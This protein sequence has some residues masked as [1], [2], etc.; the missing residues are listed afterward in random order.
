M[1]GDNPGVLSHLAQILNH[2]KLGG[3]GKLVIFPVDQG[4]EH[5]PDASF[6]KNPPAY[7][8]LYH[9]QLAVEAGCSAYAA[10]FGFIDSFSQR[11]CRRD[12]LNFK[13]Q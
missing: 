4:F 8:S 6:L 12:S 1:A 10:P 11:I 13:S 5:G 3:T 9:C 7:D 2:G